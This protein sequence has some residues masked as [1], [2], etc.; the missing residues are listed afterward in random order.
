MFKNGQNARDIRRFR[1]VQVCRVAFASSS[2]RLAA[3]FRL[4]SALARAFEKRPKRSRLSSVLTFP[5]PVGPGR[6]LTQQQIPVRIT[7]PKSIGP[8]LLG[9]QKWPNRSGHS[10]ILGY[11]RFAALHPRLLR[12]V[13]HLFVAFFL[14]LIVPSKMVKT[15]ETGA[16]L[17]SPLPGWPRL[18]AD[19]QFLPCFTNESGPD[20]SKKRGI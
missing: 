19:M 12:T 4:L 18:T 17:N 14:R 13:W 6:R 10:T 3:L 5:F 11:F 7:Q 1:S 8:F 9:V 16:V 20:P 2:G 15:L